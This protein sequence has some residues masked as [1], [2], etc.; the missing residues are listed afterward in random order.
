MNITPEQ[1]KL[2]ADSVY[3]NEDWMI[4]QGRVFSTRWL[5]SEHPYEFIFDSTDPAIVLEMIEYLV[6]EDRRLISFHSGDFYFEAALGYCGKG[7]SLTSCVI[8]AFLKHIGE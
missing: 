1:T 8:E 5:N 7:K 4:G 2:I 6:K 3:P